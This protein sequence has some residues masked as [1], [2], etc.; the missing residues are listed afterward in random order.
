MASPA[1]ARQAVAALAALSS[2]DKTAAL[3]TAL[4]Q[5]AQAA[6][7]KLGA[8][9]RAIVEAEEKLKGVVRDSAWEQDVAVARDDYERARELAAAKWLSPQAMER[10]RTAYQQGSCCQ[11]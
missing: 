11:W 8:A 5:G 9:A 2:Q 4:T 6:V 10:A 7:G 1:G 3:R